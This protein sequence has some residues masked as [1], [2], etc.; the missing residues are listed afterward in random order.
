MSDRSRDGYTLSAD[1]T[2]VEEEVRRKFAGRHEEVRREEEE[3]RRYER[4]FE[5]EEFDRKP[6]FC[7]VQRIRRAG[8]AGADHE[9]VSVEGF[10]FLGARAARPLL[11]NAGR[12]PALPRIVRLKS[13]AVAECVS[14]PMLMTSTPGSANSRSVS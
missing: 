6:G 9:A 12:R 13:A 7:G 4:A 11:L 3:T 2:R 14:A 10:H 5:R 8:E 1:P